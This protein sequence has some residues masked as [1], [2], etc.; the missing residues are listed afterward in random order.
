MRCEVENMWMRAMGGEEVICY[1][2]D[3]IAA[4]TWGASERTK[5]RAMGEA[6]PHICARIE[7]QP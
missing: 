7:G 1:R 6:P 2:R 4:G 3:E 5:T